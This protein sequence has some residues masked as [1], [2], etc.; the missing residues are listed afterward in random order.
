MDPGRID[1]MKLAL[2]RLRAA[3]APQQTILALSDRIR[4]M[5]AASVATPPETR[6]L[7]IGDEIVTQ[8]WT[9]TGWQEIARGPRSSQ[10]TEININD[11]GQDAF[12]KEVGERLGTAYTESLGSVDIAQKSL[13]NLSIMEDVLDQGI[14]TGP[15]A[16]SR[17]AVEKI[18]AQAGLIDGT[19]VANTEAYLAA[20]AQQTLALLQTGAVGA[21]TGISDADREFLAKAAG[22]SVNL[23]EESIRRIININKTVSRNVFNAHNQLVDRTRQVFPNAK[24]MVQERYYPGQRA[25]WPD[26]TTRQFDP[27]QGWVEV[28]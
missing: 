3:G 8:Q 24:D 22:G 7:K 9:G 25:K 23:T 5:E 2:E 15:F 12:T 1:S 18:L 27:I 14:I 11:Q 19:R 28:Q 6:E 13:E 10:V 21:G 20:S 17:T 4:E 16:E 26:G